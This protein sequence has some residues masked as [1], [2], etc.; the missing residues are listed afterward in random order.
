MSGLDRALATS[1]TLPHVAATLAAAIVAYQTVNANGERLFDLS[2][3]NIALVIV[4]A[5]SMIGPI[6]TER[7]VRKLRAAPAP[8]PSRLEQELDPTP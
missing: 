6:L 1:L 4:V 8:M 7:S 5:T 2:L 3:L